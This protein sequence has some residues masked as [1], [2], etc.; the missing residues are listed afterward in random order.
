M[1]ALHDTYQIHL[2]QFEG[3]F[4]LLLFFIERDELSISD[5]P[6]ARITNDFLDYLHQ[7]EKN[8]LEVAAEFILMAARL[9]KIKASMLLPRPQINEK[10]EVIDPRTELIDR[11]LEYKKYKTAMEELARLETEAQLHEKRGFAIAEMQLFKKQNTQPED[12]LVGITLFQLVQVYKK[13]LARHEVETKTPNHVIQRFPYTVEEIKGDLVRQVS[14][15]RKVDFVQLVAQKPE[16]L[17]IVFC[18]LCI[19]EL[20]QQ[21][22]VRVLVG[23]GYNNFWLVAFETEAE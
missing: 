13:V 7:M 1:V 11:L 21:R 14:V 5:I 17:F 6:I 4:D 19:L 18:F 3:P 15:A 9:M 2:P 20:I 12:E 22:A 10:G 16:K 23:E 8:K